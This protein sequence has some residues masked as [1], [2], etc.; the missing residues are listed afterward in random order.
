MQ[1][2]ALKVIISMYKQ[3]RLF[4]I[5]CF[6]AR[7]STTGKSI[8]INDSRIRAQ[9]NEWRLLLQVDAVYDDGRHQARILK[10]LTNDEIRSRKMTVPID[11]IACRWAS[12]KG[13]ADHVEAVPHRHLTM[14]T[15]HKKKDAMVVMGDSHVGEIFTYIKPTPKGKGANVATPSAQLRDS[16]GNDCTVATAFVCAVER[17]KKV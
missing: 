1:A 10:T 2:R 15:P 12:Q 11:S 3:E 16:V 7:Q 13:Y 6:E 17:V 5:Y 14:R 8:W 9:L 4:I